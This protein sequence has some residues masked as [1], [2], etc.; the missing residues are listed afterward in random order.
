MFDDAAKVDDLD[1]GACAR[2][3]EAAV[4]ARRRA[5]AWQLVLVARWADLHHP[6]SSPSPATRARSA[7]GGS[8]GTPEVTEF[9]TTELGLLL[10]VSTITA[11]V[12]LRDVLDLRHRLPRTWAAITAGELDGWKGRPLARATSALSPDQARWVD[13]ECLEALVGL[14]FGRALG[15]VGGKVLAADPAAAEERR[16]DERSRRYVTS[17]RPGRAGTDD[18][19]LQTFIARTTT[20]DVARLMGMVGQLA[21]RLEQAGSTESADGRRATALGLLADPAGACVVLAQQDEPAQAPDVDPAVE[22]ARAVGTS[23]VAGGPRVLDRLRPRTV[24]HLHL[25]EETVQG[26]SGTQ[27]VRSEGLG[28][29]TVEELRRW[30]GTEQVTVQPVLDLAGQRSVDR[31]EIPTWLDEAI[32]VR[33]SFEV[34]PWGTHASRHAD[35]DHTAPYRSPD[36]GGPPGQTRLDNLGPLGRRHHRAKTFG[37]FA[38]YQPMPGLYLWRA[39]TGSWYRVDHT[40]T[41]ALGTG[42]PDLV[43]QLEGRPLSRLECGLSDLVVALAA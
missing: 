40:G 33:E 23:L 4:T 30:L 9:A 3:L 25:A 42:T 22:A 7:V 16:R 18:A 20:K 5:E 28:A 38:C 14:P 17:T 41:T 1:T 10:E 11:S 6:G 35:K 34:F 36:T 26:R 12:L 24:V 15:V 8:E 13:R 29:L 27:V 2:E 32:S 43:L 19:G 37:G 31:Y 39:P 21:D